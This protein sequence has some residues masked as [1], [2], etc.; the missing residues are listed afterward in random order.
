MR[1]LHSLFLVLVLG[2][3]SACTT[4]STI[5]TASPDELKQQVINT[6]RAFAKT[7]ADRDFKAFATF[8][9]NEAIFFAGGEKQLRGKQAILE[10]W[11]DF[12]NKP[13]A[14]F[15]WEPETVEVLPSGTLALSSGPVHNTE[16]KLIGTFS[17]IWRQEASGTWRIVFDKGNAVC[18]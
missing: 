15:S 13:Q 8:V 7:M 2:M 12:Y 9:S 5:P 18:N 14:P 6:E 1:R 16:G 3:V 11:K 10:W 17:S 4:T